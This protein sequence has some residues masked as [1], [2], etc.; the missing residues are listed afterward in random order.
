MKNVRKVRN[1]GADERLMY[2]TNKKDEHVERL[3]SKFC[4]Y[5]YVL[6][7]NF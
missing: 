6:L 7:R 1:N 5:V 3:I 4:V 2:V